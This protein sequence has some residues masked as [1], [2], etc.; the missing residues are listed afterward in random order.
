VSSAAPTVF[1]CGLCGLQFTHGDRCCSSCA[2]GAACE[3]V[4]CP[5]CGYQFPRGSQVFEWLGRMARRIGGR[6]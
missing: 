4:K 3:L 1:A 2:L 6:A 5:R